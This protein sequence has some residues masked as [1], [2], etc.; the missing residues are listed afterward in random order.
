M[1]E[2][3]FVCVFCGYLLL[4]YN[5]AYP[6]TQQNCHQSAFKYQMDYNT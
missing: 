2:K 1:N 6:A 5:L 3:G 4:R